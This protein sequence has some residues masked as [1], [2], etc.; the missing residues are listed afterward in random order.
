MRLI[1]TWLPLV[2]VVRERESRAVDWSQLAQGLERQFQRRDPFA[3]LSVSESQVEP[4]DPLTR[5]RL[6]EWGN[7]P[8]VQ[9]LFKQY[10]AGYATVA[11]GDAERRALTALL[12]SWTPDAPHELAGTLARGLDYCVARLD[13][14]RVRL[15]PSSA[16]FRQLVFRELAKLSLAGMNQGA[17]LEGGALR[18]R[19]GTLK[20]G[21][22]QRET[23]GESSFVLGWLRPG[24]IWVSFHG[25]LSSALADRY[26]EHFGQLVRAESAATYFADASGIA[27]TDLLGRN[28]VLRSLI[29]NTQ[30]FAAIHILNWSGGVSSTG[31]ATLEGLAGLVRLTQDKDSFERTLNTVCPGARQTIAAFSQQSDALQ[32]PR[33]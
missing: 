33:R 20:V 32:H 3:L 19:S 31:Q 16:G 5:Q 6:A 10:C 27:S 23:E 18:R 12:S 2:V 24:V 21:R 11:A 8:R 1:E 22:L 15:A 4:I 25:H 26:A 9:S 7:R 13:D 14:R 28:R 29:D 17:P 30:R